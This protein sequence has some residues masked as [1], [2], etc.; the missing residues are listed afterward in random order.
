MTLTHT[1]TWARDFPGDH[2]PRDYVPTPSLPADMETLPP[3]LTFNGSGT[4]QSISCCAPVPM[5]QAQGDE[6][7]HLGRG[8]LCFGVLIFLVVVCHMVAIGRK[9]S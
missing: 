6:L 4:V 7:I 2:P 8:C 9:T 5:T 1:T 3:G